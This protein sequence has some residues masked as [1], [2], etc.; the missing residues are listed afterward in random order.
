M[1]KAM[2]PSG[3]TRKGTANTQPT[4]SRPGTTSIS[5]RPGTTSVGTRPGTTSVN[6]RPGTR[7]I[8][9]P[10]ASPTSINLKG[11]TLIQGIDEL[12]SVRSLD[13]KLLNEWGISADSARSNN[14]ESTASHSIRGGG[15]YYPMQHDD[16]PSVR[17][18]D[19]NLMKEW[20]I[21]A[22][23]NMSESD[24]SGNLKS[25]STSH[26]DDQSQG[27]LSQVDMDAMDEAI[28]L[29]ESN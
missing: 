24:L 12:P 29:L 22:R 8:Q 19:S 13:S 7:E 6:T 2:S 16:L 9:S 23:S 14:T 26:L 17:S 28:S 20:G 5:T 4:S 3:E 1:R 10:Q 18:L 27:S 15:G 25:D 21:S 11:A